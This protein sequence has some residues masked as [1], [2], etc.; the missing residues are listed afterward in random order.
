VCSGAPLVEYFP[1]R[2]RSRNREWK[3]VVGER[4]RGGGAGGR[5]THC[6][7]S[8]SWQS[9]EYEYEDYKVKVISNGRDV[10][11]RLYLG[12]SYAGHCVCQIRAVSNRYP[13]TEVSF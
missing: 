6:G 4:M 3:G 13:L 10:L 7:R 9:Y 11:Q 2:S 5:M 1:V 8:K 12:P